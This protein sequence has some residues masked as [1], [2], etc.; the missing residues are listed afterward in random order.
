MGRESENERLLQRGAM[1]WVAAAAAKRKS[2]EGGPE[3][4]G[5]RCGVND[6]ESGGKLQPLKSAV[7]V[8]LEVKLC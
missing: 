1:E 6:R 5:R 3:K 2:E 8:Y 7:G 4:E